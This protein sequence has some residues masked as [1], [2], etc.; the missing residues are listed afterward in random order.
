MSIKKDGISHRGLAV[1]IE[2]LILLFLILQLAVNAWAEPALG[3]LAIVTPPARS[4][5]ESP[6]VEVVVRVPAGSVDELQILVNNRKLRL[7]KRRFDKFNVCFDGIELSYGMNDIKVVGLM[8]G[9][10]VEEAATQIFFRSDLASAASSAPDG[11]NKFLFHD[12]ASEKVCA[13]C[14][15]LDFSSFGEGEMAAEKSPCYL[16]HKKILSNYAVVHGPAAVWSCLSCHDKKGT[17]KLSVVRP[18]SKLCFNCHENVWEKMKFWHGP[19]AAGSCATCHSPHA[20]NYPFFLRAPK[21]DLC[22]GCHEEILTK[23]HVI[24][25]FSASNAGHPVRKSVDPYHPNREFTCVSCHNP[26]AGTSWTFL[27]NYDGTSEIYTFC[28]TCHAM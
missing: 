26:H 5:V 4:V 19:T 10:K 9:K 17:P 27:Q 20:S 28:R 16:C 21:R 1:R 6:L 23:P 2:L 15:Q 13:P 22:L 24:M 8:K 12:N 18:D 7:P 11:F 3:H 25:G 14:H